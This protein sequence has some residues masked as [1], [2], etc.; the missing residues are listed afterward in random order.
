MC[1]GR[2]YAAAAPPPPPL[3]RQVVCWALYA[4]APTKVAAKSELVIYGIRS[5]L[6]A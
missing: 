6:F 2:C 5:V 4:A 3:R 1:A